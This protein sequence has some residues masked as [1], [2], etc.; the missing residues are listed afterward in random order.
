LW[1]F[2]TQEETVNELG[3]AEDAA[4]SMLESINKYY[5]ARAKLVTKALKHPRVQ[6]YAQSIIGA[7]SLIVESKQFFT[8][9]WK[10]SNCHIN[11]ELASAFTF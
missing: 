9:T 11:H 1:W 4:F 6:D 8:G 7:S 3:R 5:L 10:Q 2:L